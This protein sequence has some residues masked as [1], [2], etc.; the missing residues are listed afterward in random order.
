[1]TPAARPPETAVPKVSPRLVKLDVGTLLWRV[2]STH[3]NA[4]S[5]R[6]QPTDEV[7]G[8]GRFDATPT[9]PYPFLYAAPVPETAVLETITR[10]L[11]H[12][13]KHF[14]TIRREN[15][16]DLTLSPLLVIEPLTLI[17]L[18]SGIDLACALQDEWLIQCESRDYPQTRRWARWLRLQVPTA[19][20]I[21]WMSRRDVGQ[22]C[23]VLFGDRCTSVLEPARLPAIDL[24]SAAGA[25]WLNH[26][27]KPYRT[28]IMRPLRRTASA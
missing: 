23:V 4:I 27:L 14:R 2:H 20:G 16:I 18:M 10:D 6:N 19:Q 26:R 11:P 13:P 28:R 8:G 25:E 12:H 7:F 21:A 5:F 1:M 3:R 17:S 22:R 24:A 15:V 9:D